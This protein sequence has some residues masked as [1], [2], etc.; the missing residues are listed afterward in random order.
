MPRFVIAV[1]LF[2]YLGTSFAQITGEDIAGQ[3]L[4]FEFAAFTN[5]IE[6]WSVNNFE[7]FFANDGAVGST[8]TYKSSKDYHYRSEIQVYEGAQKINGFLGD[9]VYMGSTRTNEGD[10]TEWHYEGAY[11]YHPT[12]WKDMALPEIFIHGVPMLIRQSETTGTKR[13]YIMYK[14]S[15][16]IKMNFDFY[17]DRQDTEPYWSNFNERYRTH[18][19]DQAVETDFDPYTPGNYTIG[20]GDD[21]AGIKI[22][23]TTSPSYKVHRDFIHFA[24]ERPESI[25]LTVTH[26]LFRD[27]RDLTLN[28]SADQ[29]LLPRK[30]FTVKTMDNKGALIVYGDGT[31][32]YFH[33]L[34]ALP[35]NVNLPRFLLDNPPYL[36]SYNAEEDSL[37]IYVHNSARAKTLIGFERWLTIAQHIRVLAITLSVT[38]VFDSWTT[39]SPAQPETIENELG[40]T[41]LTPPP[42]DPF[43]PELYA[44][45]TDRRGV[46]L[47]TE[48]ILAQI[49]CIDVAFAVDEDDPLQTELDKTEM[50][51]LVERTLL[52]SKIGDVPSCER[53]PF[54]TINEFFISVRTQQE[55]DVIV[56][57]P[58]VTSSTRLPNPRTNERFSLLPLDITNLVI[59]N[60]E[61]FVTDVEQVIVS[62]IKQIAEEIT[63]KQQ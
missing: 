5:D 15:D 62:T 41:T 4:G 57:S 1:C 11:T 47:E 56:L 6:E 2:M 44:L 53:D 16:F 24:S 35:S 22:I 36:V 14:K 49:S 48:E 3:W 51:V 8:I 43:D 63:L 7:M 25:G 45:L 52:T 30:P 50:R 28:N 58:W 38:E 20:L 37:G 31:E 23:D 10:P 9:S 32:T 21:W 39:S 59:S 12:G 46:Q 19:L 27:G 61:D 40:E 33:L 54:S 18:L 26:E 55:D 42:P 34:H 17:S 29:M 60:P 13:L